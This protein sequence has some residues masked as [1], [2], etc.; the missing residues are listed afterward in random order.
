MQ[1][2][3]TQ[4]NRNKV[5]LIVDIG[6]FG[7]F[8]VVMAPHFS[9]IA[10]HEWLSIS[11]GAAIIAHLLLHWQWLVGVTKQFFRKA[12]WSSR[13]NYLLNTLLFIDMTI[14]IFSGL[15][16]SQ[17][18]LPLLGI[19]LA[20]GGSWRQLH[21]LSADLSLLLIGLHIALHWHWIVN[22]AKR[23]LIA[24]LA[25]WRRRPERSTSSLSLQVS[26]PVEDKQSVV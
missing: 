11:F 6:I 25:P 20:A 23:Y 12:Q 15:M 10:I 24:P 13:I 17:S 22:A 9:G 21:G 5:N 4:P 2:A 8:L 14:I 26:V 19:Q 3:H 7:A 16:I 18:A 1:Q